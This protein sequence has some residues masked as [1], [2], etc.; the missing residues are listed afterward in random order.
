MAAVVDFGPP[1]LGD[2][3]VY[4]GAWPTVPVHLDGQDVHPLPVETAALLGISGRTALL[5]FDHLACPAHL[6]TLALPGP[7][8]LTP[9]SLR[10][11]LVVHS[12]TVTPSG[13][14]RATIARWPGATSQAVL[15]WLT[16]E[17][18]RLI[19]EVEGAQA[20][21][22][23]L[24]TADGLVAAYRPRAGFTTSGHRLPVPVAGVACTG[25]G[26]PPAMTQAEVRRHREALAG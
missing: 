22:V 15:L 20:D 19:D 16:A 4:P 26:L 25:P 24:P 1:P 6:A 5:A 2:P 18:H 21:R 3:T 12:A 17:Q 14:V 23:V 7:V 9:T 13:V 10:N 11:H 8:L